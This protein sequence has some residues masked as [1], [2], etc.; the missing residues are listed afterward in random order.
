MFRRVSVGWCNWMAWCKTNLRDFFRW[1]FFFFKSA[2]IFACAFQFSSKT[3]PCIFRLVSPVCFW[4]KQDWPKWLSL[5]NF[6]PSKEHEF[7]KKKTKKGKTFFRLLQT[8]WCKGPCPKMLFFHFVAFIVHSLILNK[9]H[10]SQKKYRG[11]F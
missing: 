10:T 3:C 8:Q 11:L 6:L 4:E 7:C 5:L 1:D 2:W 9:E